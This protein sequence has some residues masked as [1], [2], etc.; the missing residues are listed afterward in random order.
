MSTDT[1][2]VMLHTHHFI[3]KQGT[4]YSNKLKS[5]PEYSLQVKLTQDPLYSTMSAEFQQESKSTNGIN[6][7]KQQ[8]S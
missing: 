8:H 4:Y 3:I 6:Q 1:F 2:N 5:V 7:T